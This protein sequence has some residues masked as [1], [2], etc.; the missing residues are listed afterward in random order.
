MLRRKKK[1]INIAFPL[2][3]L[4]DIAFLLLIF[5]LLCAM[6][7]H[8][9]KGLSFFL[10]KNTALKQHTLVRAEDILT[11]TIDE[12]GHTSIDKKD[13]LHFSC[14]KKQVHAFLCNYG[15]EKTLSSS[16]KNVHIF[17]KNHPKT[18]YQCYIKT[19]DIVKQVYATFYA[20]KLGI[21]S[22]QFEQKKKNLDKNTIKLLQH[23][24]MRIVLVD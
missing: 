4:A 5:F 12:Q 1:L 8:K 9:E 17:I 21:N 22:K 10:P 14:L 7:K 3:A 20:Q 23:I 11:I 15:K 13:L 18:P 2:G 19:L 6:L 16:P 24:P